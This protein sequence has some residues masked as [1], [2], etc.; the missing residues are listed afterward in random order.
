MCIDLIHKFGGM[1]EK[2]FVRMMIESKRMT[3]QG[4][5]AFSLYEF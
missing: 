2:K 3:R 5:E 1:F 4:K